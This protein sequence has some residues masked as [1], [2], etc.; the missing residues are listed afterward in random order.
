MPVVIAILAAVTLG[1][2]LKKSA[3]LGIVIG[4]AGVNN[5]TLG[6]GG[7][8]SGKSWAAGLILISIGV[9]A[10]A[11]VY[12][13]WRNLLSEWRGVEILA[14]QLLVSTLAVAPIALLVEGAGGHVFAQLPTLG[15][16]AV[17]NYVIPQI[18]MFW[19]LTRT[20]AVRAALSN[21]LAPLIATMLATVVLGQKIT[22]LIIVGG[23]LIIGGAVLVNTARQRTTKDQAEMAVLADE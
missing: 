21:Y 20:S 3:V 10:A 11:V 22:P 12:V 1:E 4:T 5:L 17:V 7:S 8:L 13:G 6:K 14:P 19:L 9:V 18:A 15:A 16:L 23:V 2:T